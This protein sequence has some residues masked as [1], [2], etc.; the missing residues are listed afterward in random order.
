MEEDTRPLKG[1]HTSYLKNAEPLLN[2]YFGIGFGYFYYEIENNLEGYNMFSD[3]PI[4]DALELDERIG[5]AFSFEPMDAINLIQLIEINEDN[6]KSNNEVSMCLLL[7]AYVIKDQDWSWEYQLPEFAE[8]INYENVRQDLLKLYIFVNG[9]Q[10]SRADGQKLTLKHSIGKIDIKNYDN[11]FTNSF[12]K[13]YLDIYLA[14]VKSVRQAEE[15]LTTYK[16]SAGRRC[17]D[18]RIPIILY[19]MYRMMNDKL[20]LTS[21][22]SDS[23][24][25]FIIS[26]MQF[27]GIVGKDTHIDNQWIRAQITY[28]KTKAEPPKFPFREIPRKG[29]AEDI[30]EALK[31]SGKRLY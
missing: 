4:M 1:V 7:L 21:P 12:I 13:D 17:T 23:L 3:N 18:Q 16:K 31:S 2:E 10:S 6:E 8:Y 27:T 19:G 30:M 9:P 25:E 24:C 15:E 26:F 14:D 20:D 28:I 11:W 5:F 29:K 22:Q